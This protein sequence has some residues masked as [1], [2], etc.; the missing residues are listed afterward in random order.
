MASIT[1]VRGQNEG[2]YY[3]LGKRTMV[4]GRQEGCPIQV[5]DDRVSRR[6][7]QIRYDEHDGSY[8][9]LDMKSANGTFL[10][11]RKVETDIALRDNDEIEIGGA[12]LIFSNTDFPD[13][14]SALAHFKKQGERSRPTIEGH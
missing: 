6:H 3:P 11:G 5:V 14:S 12:K 2:D 9:L 1:I 4:I 10:N 8:H 7:V 13:R